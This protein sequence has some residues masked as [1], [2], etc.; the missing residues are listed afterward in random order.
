[1]QPE[2]VSPTPHHS[3]LFPYAPDF[4]M[5]TF[6]CCIPVRLGVLLLS[7]LTTVVAALLAY[8]QLFQLI[9]YA[10]QYDTFE[11]A[12]RGALAGITILIAL[13]SVFGFIGSLV[14]GRRL[15]SF[16]S[17]MLWVGL[18]AFVVVGAIEIW[19][20]FNNKQDFINTCENRTQLNT[21][22][23]EIQSLFG[24]TYEGAADEI[25][26]KAADASAIIVAVL[27]GILV[28]VLMWLIG[29]V[30]KYKHQL[31]QEKAS[32]HHRGG[33]E[34]GY[35]PPPSRSNR[36]M[37]GNIGKGRNHG[38]VKTQTSEYNNSHVPLTQQPQPAGFYEH[39]AAPAHA[40]YGRA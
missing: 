14:A 5:R 6:C 23:A 2:I 21:G 11:K 7:P 16:Y 1:M 29:I 24:S 28:L 33:V 20:L 34:S 3:Y 17:N 8:T 12:I 25:C 38:Y 40:P 4:T 35:Y 37:F 27:F 26:Q 18:L 10:A 22:N 15:V 19:Q 31:Q 36:G 32:H 13:A 39:T 9:H 30:T